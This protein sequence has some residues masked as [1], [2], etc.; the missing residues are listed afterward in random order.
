MAFPVPHRPI[1]AR[2]LSLQ[3][4]PLLP[5]PH[6]HAVLDGLLY[7]TAIERA[8]RTTQEPPRSVG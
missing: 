5:R 7:M 4:A 8:D 2:G 6:E 1:R 3:A